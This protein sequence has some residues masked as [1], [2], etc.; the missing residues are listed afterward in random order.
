[1]EKEVFFMFGKKK[2]KQVLTLAVVGLTCVWGSYGTAAAAP[3]A[4]PTEQTA[5]RN[6]G[7]GGSQLRLTKEWDKVFL[8]NKEVNRKR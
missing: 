3:Q 5:M 6:K 4:N 7:Q 2:L 8:Q 1:M